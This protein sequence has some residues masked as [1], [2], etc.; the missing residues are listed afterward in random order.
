MTG[1]QSGS[2]IGAALLLLLAGALCELVGQRLNDANV[3]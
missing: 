2:M 1:V 3:R